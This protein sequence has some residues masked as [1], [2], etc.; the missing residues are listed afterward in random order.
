MHGGG[1]PRQIER[2]IP[3]SEFAFS[4]AYEVSFGTSGKEREPSLPSPD[5]IAEDFDTIVDGL[6]LLERDYLGGSGTRG[7]GQVKFRGLAARVAVG[8]VDE[9]LLEKLN[10]RLAAV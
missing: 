1:K 4:L 5:E 10:A 3:G 7:Y 2:V 6:A 9:S 8:S